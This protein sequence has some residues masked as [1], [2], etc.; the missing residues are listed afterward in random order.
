[1]KTFPAIRLSVLTAICAGLAAVAGFGRAHADD[2]FDALTKDL[3]KQAI[4][5]TKTVKEPPPAKASND[6]AA[7][8]APMPGNKAPIPIPETAEDVEYD[9]ADGS[10]EFT[11]A[12]SVKQV[13]EFYRAAM[14]PLEWTAHP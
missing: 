2:T 8:L 4:G 7:S 1:M 11:S 10:L 5:A 3:L 6:A 12:S 14:K 9:D 13:A